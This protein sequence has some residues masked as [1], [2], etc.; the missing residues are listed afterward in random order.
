MSDSNNPK[1]RLLTEVSQR[2]Y[3]L[4][5]DKSTG[6]KYIKGEF[7]IV[8]TPTEN[9]RVYSRA[10][11][12][13]EIRKL[14]EKIKNRSLLGELDHPDDGKPRLSR[15]SH[16]ITE[17][18]LG[19]DNIIRGKAE[20]LDTD[21]GRNLRAIAEAGVKIGVSLRGYGSTRMENNVEIV[22][23]DFELLT[24]DFVVE[25]AGHSYAVLSEQ[26]KLTGGL[27][28]E[29]K[30]KLQVI[31][32]YNKK[33]EEAVEKIKAEQKAIISRKLEEATLEIRKAVEKEFADRYNSDPNYGLAKQVIEEVISVLKPFIP[34]AMM[35]EETTKMVN[36]LK[37]SNEK[38][39]KA[40]RQAGFI[41][42]LEQ[43]LANNPNKE[44][45]Y[46]L[47]DFETITDDN[48]LIARVNKIKESINDSFEPLDVVELKNENDKLNKTLE[49]TV[50]NL[51]ETED[52]LKTLKEEYD[53][54][55]NMVKEKEDEIE[56]KKDEIDML[57]DKLDKLEDEFKTLKEEYD[58][59]RDI[60][61]EK[62]D[63]IAMLTDKLDKLE[64]ENSRLVAELEEKEDLIIKLEQEL[65]SLEDEYI[66][67]DS[68]K[69]DIIKSK[70]S[71]ID[72]LNEDIKKLSGKIELMEAKLNGLR[73]V[74]FRP[75]YYRYEKPIMESKS[76]AEIDSIIS[77]VPD[78]TLADERVNTV[79]KTILESFNKEK[80]KPKSIVTESTSDGNRLNPNGEGVSELINLGLSL[81]DIKEMD[82]LIKG[83]NG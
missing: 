4:E 81:Q 5:E 2:N 41:L 17:L 61:K 32:E 26:K 25:P 40:S 16:L 58:R 66:S 57:T 77:N 51:R 18:Y 15:V 78:R 35:D 76:K 75:D 83:R 59:V 6:R 3:A 20:I 12:E 37:D 60:V 33:L 73:K 31:E 44:K 49:D 14:Q 13:R 39:L 63:E 7:G 27:L 42:K 82:E 28:M 70:E 45:Y 67:R 23:D 55:Q 54:V 19:D 48:D 22:E 80:V 52:E 38:L 46:E 9:N 8:D 56:K 62:E 24:F 43:M 64:D 36:E 10:L 53:R 34:F 74:A 71:E 72:K 65:K 29:N 50:N 21:N 47:I 69:D 68:E 30:D 1:K 11:M 79:K